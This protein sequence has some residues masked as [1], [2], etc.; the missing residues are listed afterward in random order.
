MNVKKVLLGLFLVGVL[1]IAVVASGCIGGQQTSTVTSTPTETSLQGKIVFA[2][3]GAPNEI[4]YWKGVIAEFEKKY[5]GVTVELKRQATDTEQRRLDLVNALRGKSS[6]PDVFLMDVAWLGQF[7]ASGWLEP[8]D[9]YVQKDN[10]DLSVFF[11]SVINLA[12]K[13]GGKLYALPVYIDAGLLYY[14]KD[15]LEKYGYSKP[16]ET[17]QE[18]VEMAQKIQSGERETNPNFWGFVWQGKQYESLVCDFVEYVYSNGGSLGEFKDGKWVPTLNKPENVEALQFMV[19][20]IHKYKISP[21]NTYTEM[22]EEPVRLMFQ[23]GNA[24][25][26]RNWPYAWGLHNA[27]DS[28]VKGKVGVA[29]LPHFPGHKSAATLGGWHIGISKYSDNKA[30]AWEFVKFVE[31][32]SVQKGFA[33][34]LGWNPGRVDVYDD[35]AV[36]SKSPHLKELRA[37]FENAVPRPIVPY[38]PQLS[39]IIQKYVNSAL[40]GKISPQ[41]ALDK[42]Q[43]EA[44]ELVKQYS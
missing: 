43:K 14:R 41:E 4:E 18:L 22:T 33:M 39:E 12:D 38:Y 2:V 11:Q 10:Y 35:P 16:P 27:D 29:P 9:D 5:P 8:L 30:L 20:L 37:V 44:E 15:L 21:P 7:I 42:A 13:Q 32:Y 26:E 23:Q 6:D 40:A 1:G 25:F 36:V 19:D 24:A 31:S 3:G 17:W 34:N 28:P